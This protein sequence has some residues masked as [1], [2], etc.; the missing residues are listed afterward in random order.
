MSI[1]KLTAAILPVCIV[2]SFA[3]CGS[4]EDNLSK[5]QPDTGVSTS[6]AVQEELTA[7]PTEVLTEAVTEKYYDRGSNADE[8]LDEIKEKI[9]NGEYE[10]TKN[11]EIAD[12]VMVVHAY[13]MGYAFEDDS[14]SYPVG[15]SRGIIDKKDLYE[16]SPSD[17][18]KLVLEGYGIDESNF[19]RVFNQC[20]D[21]VFYYI[22]MED[23]YYDDTAEPIRKYGTRKLYSY[24]VHLEDNTI[25][26][27]RMLSEVKDLD[28]T[29][30]AH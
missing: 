28:I 17:D 10:L 12:K 27:V 15:N 4:G 3:A 16:P 18:I 6:T 9:E 26:E 23:V 20:T 24:I 25:S 7:A 14:L 30:G 21:V 29:P 2:L 11:E 13:D 8:L 22:N 19:T 5:T 1:K